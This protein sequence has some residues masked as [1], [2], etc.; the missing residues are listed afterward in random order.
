MINSILLVRFGQILDV[1]GNCLFWY[2]SCKL[3]FFLAPVELSGRHINMFLRCHVCWQHER[4]ILY[5]LPYGCMWTRW[6]KRVALVKVYLHNVFCSQVL[7]QIFRLLLHM[8]KMCTTKGNR[9]CVVNVSIF[10]SKACM[11]V[12]WFQFT[13]SGAWLRLVCVTRQFFLWSQRLS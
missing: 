7:D 12:V 4:I 1:L 8:L 2:L 10:W 3:A 11:E 6:G 13:S 5:Q 9:S